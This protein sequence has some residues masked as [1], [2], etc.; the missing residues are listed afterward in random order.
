MLLFEA[1]VDYPHPTIL[2]QV[3][4]CVEGGKAVLLSRNDVVFKDFIP[5]SARARPWPQKLVYR[6]RY[7]KFIIMLPK[8]VMKLMGE[9][10]DIKVGLPIVKRRKFLNLYFF[11]PFL[12]FIFA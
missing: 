8:A 12:N 5:N 10:I 2:S 7:T 11:A 3:S 4:K 1:I 9:K 6:Y